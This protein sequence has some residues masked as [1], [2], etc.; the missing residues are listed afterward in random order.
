M[1]KRAKAMI[2]SKRNERARKANKKYR[3]SKQKQAKSKQKA[4]KRRWKQEKQAK[5]NGTAS[6]S[7][8]KLAKA[9][10][11]QAKQRFQATKKVTTSL[12]NKRENLRMQSLIIFGSKMIKLTSSLE[13]QVFFQTSQTRKWNPRFEHC[14]WL[15]PRSTR[16]LA[17]RWLFQPM[18]QLD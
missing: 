16:N 1:E 4:R 14:A 9:M 5:N 10:K 11:K 15:L 6:K 2:A 12:K 7:M 8:E 3:K 13:I 18:R 17:K